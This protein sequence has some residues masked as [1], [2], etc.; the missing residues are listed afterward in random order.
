M[1][2]TH[3]KITTILFTLLFASFFASAQ[4]ERKPAVVKTDSAASSTSSDKQ[5]N[6]QGR[7]DRMKDLDLTKEQRSK[8]KEIR[9]SGKAAKDAI[10]NNTNLSDAEKKKQMNALKKEQTQK[11][12][13]ILT[14]EQ[15]EKFKADT[16]NN[17]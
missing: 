2:F 8:M 6:K 17:L 10:E 4:I 9:Q 1:K 12:Q 13:A 7:K 14:D 5:M 16:K 11:I 3:M 15:R